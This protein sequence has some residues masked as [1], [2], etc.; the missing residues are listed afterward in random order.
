MGNK[1]RAKFGG[2]RAH[3]RLGHTRAISEWLVMQHPLDH[4]KYTLHIINIYYSAPCRKKTPWS[5]SASELYRPSDRRL[6]AK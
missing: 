4:F 5:E 6:S 3:D 2:G 1:K